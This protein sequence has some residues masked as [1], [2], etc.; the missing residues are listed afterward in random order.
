MATWCVCEGLLQLPPI[1]LCVLSPT[2]VNYW[3]TWCQRK[4]TTVQGPEIKVRLSRH[5]RGRLGYPLGNKDPPHLTGLLWWSRE[6]ANAVS[7]AASLPGC[8]GDL[9]EAGRDVGVES[10]HLDGCL[11]LSSSLLLPCRP[12]VANF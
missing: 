9:S 10:P 7:R 4:T 3:A 8:R 11:P 6:M 5:T 1:P 2:P 12:T